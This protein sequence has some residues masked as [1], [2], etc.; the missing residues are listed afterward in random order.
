M[1]VFFDYPV[2]AAYGRVV[3]KNKIYQHSGASSAL[4]DLF[5]TQVDQIVWKYKL[6]PETIN[7]VATHSVS[8]IQIFGISLRQAELDQDVLRAIDSAIPF[9]IIFELFWSGKQKVVAAF[10]RPSETD[11]SRMVLSGYFNTD[12]V[13]ATTTRVV[14]PLALD[15]GR[16]YAILLQDLMPLPARSEETL[17]KWVERVE[18]VACKS[19]EVEKTEARLSKEKQFKRKVEINAILR[20]LK[21]EL[22]HLR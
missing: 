16:L 11:A 3:P 7:L 15:M 19:R 4:K 8:E 20:Q 13:P 14:I 12:W 1:T 9:P 5:I 6:A 22:E 17:A 21:L 18:L 10:K 2:S